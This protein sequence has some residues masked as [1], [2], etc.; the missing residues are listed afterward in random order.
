M[1]NIKL[2]TALIFMQVSFKA[3]SASPF[4]IE[5]FMPKGVTET[6]LVSQMKHNFKLEVLGTSKELLL[7]TTEYTNKGVSSEVIQRFALAA[8]KFNNININYKVESKR[9][10]LILSGDYEMS[11]TDYN[12]YADAY[13][14]NKV[15]AN[16]IEAIALQVN[17]LEKQLSESTNKSQAH[18]LIR[19]QNDIWHTSNKLNVSVKQLALQDMSVLLR[20]AKNEHYELKRKLSDAFLVSKNSLILEHKELDVSFRQNGE[21]KWSATV[22]ISMNWEKLI[23][24][25]P[26]HIKV[27]TCNRYG[28]DYYMLET[29][30]SGLEE[31]I[32][33]VIRKDKV[34]TIDS[35]NSIEQMVYGMGNHC[36]S[37]LET[38]RNFIFIKKATFVINTWT[39]EATDISQRF[40]AIHL[41]EHNAKS[42]KLIGY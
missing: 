7:R 31:S 32:S 42:S 20:V 8:I 10:K 39:S 41:R 1:L 40:A 38:G 34:L 33:A 27:K 2:I 11:T 35:E 30:N 9:L 14:K 3:L 17:S 24:T 13:F 16:K 4:L 6:E 26:S 23:T 36:G 22:S 15:L 18:E 37:F 5:A 19:L 28:N 29:P 12:N 21:H 25:L